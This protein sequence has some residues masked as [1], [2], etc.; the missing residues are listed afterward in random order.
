MQPLLIV[1]SRPSLSSIIEVVGSPCRCR[2]SCWAARPSHPVGRVGRRLLLEEVLALDAVGVA[3]ERDRP[4]AQVGE[5]D[6]RDRGV[7]ADQVALRDLLVGEEDLALV[8]ELEL[9]LG[10]LDWLLHGVL[11]CDALEHGRAQAPLARP[12]G[13]LHLA[14]E[15]GLD[16]GHARARRRRRAWERPAGARC[17]ARAASSRAR[18]SR[19]S[20]SERPLPQLP[21]YSRSSVASISAPSLRARSLAARVAGDQQDRLLAELDLAPVVAAPAGPVGRGHAL[22]HDALEPAPARGVEQRGAV[23]VDLR[24]HDRSAPRARSARSAA[25]V[26]GAHGSQI[27]GSPSISST[28][29]TT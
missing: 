6:R 18:R 10:R 25:R 16:P 17:R 2:P 27:T 14:R 26:A 13:E 24:E 4:V 28:S 8:G 29:K 20:S 15:H 19:M 3:H 22:G 21:A 11:L 1:Q 5:Q 12:L 9:A 23:V 7:V